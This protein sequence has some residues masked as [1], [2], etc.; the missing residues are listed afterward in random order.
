MAKKRTFKPQKLKIVSKTHILSLKKF[1]L[2]RQ[3]VF[4]ATTASPIDLKQRKMY[5][6]GGG[7]IMEKEYI[8]TLLELLKQTPKNK[9]EAITQLKQIG[10]LNRKGKLAKSH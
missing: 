6:K 10:V 4:L 8:K 9:K 2:V 1:F 7:P 3:I 5:I